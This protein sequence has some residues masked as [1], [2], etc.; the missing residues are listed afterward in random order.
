MSKALQELQKI[1][2]SFGVD[3]AYY[4]LEGSFEVVERE[5]KAFEIIKNNYCGKNYT[6]IYGDE[7]VNE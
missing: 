1:K 5:L 3:P 2:E 6:N 4:G 7:M